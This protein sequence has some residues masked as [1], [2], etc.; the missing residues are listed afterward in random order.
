MVCLVSCLTRS[1]YHQHFPNHQ[2]EVVSVWVGKPN[3]DCG[4]TKGHR[5]VSTATACLSMFSSPSHWIR[6]SSQLDRLSCMDTWVLLRAI[7]LYP[8]G[9]LPSNDQQFLAVLVWLS[10]FGSPY[11]THIQHM[12][13]LHRDRSVGGGH[14]CCALASGVSHSGSSKLGLSG[15]VRYGQVVRY[16]YIYVNK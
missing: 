13:L 11:H 16:I 15:T 14:R 8:S 7:K 3:G 5:W 2:S 6:T 4:Y 1:S 9:M 12:G 10:N